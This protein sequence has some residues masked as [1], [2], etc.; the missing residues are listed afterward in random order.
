MAS[1][2]TAESSQDARKRAAGQWLRGQREQR[3]WTGQQLADLVGVTRMQISSYERG[4]D[5]VS[6]ERA[7]DIARALSMNIIDVRRGLGLW[8]PD[9]LEAR[10]GPPEEAIRADETLTAD[11]R[12][13]LLS[14]IAT[15]RAQRPVR[16]GSGGRPSGSAPTEPDPYDT[17]FDP[18]APPRDDWG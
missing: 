14:M 10:I 11:Q 3:G 4:R 9:G 13:L 16:V 8:L 15:L 12:E 7:E 17:S 6:D 2:G 1:T 5:R 18:D